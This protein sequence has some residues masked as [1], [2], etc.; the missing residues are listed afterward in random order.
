IAESPWGQ[1]L[2]SN[3]R[4]EEEGDRLTISIPPRGLLYG[5]CWFFFLWSSVWN[6]IVALFTVFAVPAAFRGEIKMEG[7]NQTLSPWIFCAFL[8]PFWLIGIGSML[9]VLNWSRRRAQVVFN[10]DVLSIDEITLFGITHH[11]WRCDVV[12]N[13]EPSS[14]GY[15]PQRSALCIQHRDGSQS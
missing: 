10:S 12:T 1:P 3:A 2:A 6:L 14:D 4:V 11:R 13:V 5:A 7:A 9:T 8:I 15:A